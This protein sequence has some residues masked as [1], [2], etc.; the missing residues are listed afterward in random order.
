M[1]GNWLGR[2]FRTLDETE[3]KRGRGAGRQAAP[4]ASNAEATV[5]TAITTIIVVITK[6]TQ[7]APE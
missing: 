7:G 1:C 6:F 5:A 4:P 2:V 3:L